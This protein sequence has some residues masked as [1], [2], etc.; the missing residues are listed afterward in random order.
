MITKEKAKLALAYL[1]PVHPG[2][3]T[4]TIEA[5]VSQ[6]D[7]RIIQDFGDS[8]VLVESR[9][10]KQWVLGGDG[11]RKH[12]TAVCLVFGW[13]EYV[14]ERQREEEDEDLGAG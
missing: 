8:L 2:E 14:A 3:D 4:D 1:P 11:R 12:V 10:G 7:W 6:Q 13:E 9:R 5:I